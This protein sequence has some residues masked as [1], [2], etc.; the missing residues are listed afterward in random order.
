MNQIM[1]G[2]LF[3]TN[4][5]IVWL[6]CFTCRCSNDILMLF[7]TPEVKQFMYG[8]EMQ[9]KPNISI[10]KVCLFM[11]K[12]L[13][14]ISTHMYT[15]QN[16]TKLSNIKIQRVDGLIGTIDSVLKGECQLS[17]VAPL[18]LDCIV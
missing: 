6:H 18:R 1:T 5:I 10:K 17:G 4:T 16:S 13:C 9:P 11:T 2:V 3:T 8:G 7:K 14:F 12:I 15:T